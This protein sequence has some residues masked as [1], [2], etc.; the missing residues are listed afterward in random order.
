MTA[1]TTP[2]PTSTTATPSPGAPATG[3]VPEGPARR[4]HPAWLEALAPALAVAVLLTVLVSAFAWPAVRSAPHGIGLAV[5]APAPVAAQL[6]GRLEAAAGEDAFDVTVVADRA[7][8]EQAI[9]DREVYGA[10]VVGPS[11]GEVLVAS[12]ASPAV[13][14]ALTQ[15]AA[16]MP[17]EAGGPLPVTDVVALP[18]T[19][20]RGVGLAT[21]LLP[22]LAGGIALGAIGSLRVRR[23]GTRVLALALGAA[24]GGAVV[25]GL[26]DGWLGALDGSPWLLWSVAALVIGAVAATVA[27]LH[28]HLGTAGIGLAALVV[29]VLGNPLSGVAS[30][31]E[32]LPA[33][34][35]A[36]GQWLPAGAGATA[37]RSVAFFDGAASG[38]ALLALSAWLVAGLLL[39]VLPARRS[40]A[41]SEG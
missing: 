28:R 10:V 14:Q 36:F 33:G 29:V 37:L 19:D 17:A 27:G 4:S 6:E 9:R 15:L 5:A 3:G 35:G 25:I 22:L 39:L 13:A 16:R 1:T 2:D 40:G 12:A 11:G 8:A 38:A 20:P 30:A 21:G 18:A 41:V 34:W 32:M 24:A 7:A 26:L 31:P 23:T